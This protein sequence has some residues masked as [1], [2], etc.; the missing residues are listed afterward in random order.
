MNDH[1]HSLRVSKRAT[2]A[3]Q[4]ESMLRL[5]AFFSVSSAI[6]WLLLVSKALC[7]YSSGMPQPAALSAIQVFSWCIDAA[8]AAGC[9]LLAAAAAGCCCCWLLLLLLLLAAAAA[10]L[11]LLGCCCWAVLLCCCCWLL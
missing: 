11:L 6:Q 10:G 9:W 1:W 2:R 5:K 7:I 8:A 3:Q 4:K